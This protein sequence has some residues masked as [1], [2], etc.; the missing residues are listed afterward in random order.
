MSSMSG[1]STSSRVSTSSQSSAAARK[2]ARASAEAN[3]LLF[4][5]PTGSWPPHLATHTMTSLKTK[6]DAVITKLTNLQSRK[7]KLTTQG[8][9]LKKKLLKIRREQDKVAWKAYNYQE[10]QAML[11]APAR[12]AGPVP[13]EG[14]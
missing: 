6:A 12:P 1:C 14:S 10:Y 9:H 2:K 13:P 4:K 7:N 3:A 8:V 11:P 5:T